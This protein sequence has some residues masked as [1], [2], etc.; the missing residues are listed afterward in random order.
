MSSYSVGPGP[1]AVRI[2]CG[3]CGEKIGRIGSAVLTELFQIEPSDI[4]Q[5]RGE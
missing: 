1:K 5:G 3:S 2:R 4:K